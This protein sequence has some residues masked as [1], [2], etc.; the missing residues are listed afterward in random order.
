MKKLILL[1]VLTA[2]FSAAFAQTPAGVPE[3]FSC[4]F[5]MVD[6]NSSKVLAE[7]TGYVQGDC[8]RLE[9]P[10]MQIWCNGIDRW[11]YSPVSD[12]LVIQKNDVS[13][14]KDVSISKASGGKAKVVYDTY[15]I[16]IESLEARTEA[17]SATFFIIDPEVFGLDTIITDLR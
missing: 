15:S 11:I 17:W 4:R 5:K 13:F 8:Y 16:E 6:N 10:Q 9:T 2:V 14:L 12:E 7:G 3:R 1:S